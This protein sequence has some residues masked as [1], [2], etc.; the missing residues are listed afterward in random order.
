MPWRL[1]YKDRRTE[2]A[3]ATYTFGFGVV[4][5]G[6]SASMTSPSWATLLRFMSEGNWGVLFILVG[7]IHMLA[8]GI[9]GA[10]WWTPLVRSVTAGINLLAYATIL[11]G[12]F[13]ENSV[14]PGVPT[15][16]LICWLLK[17]I[18][19]RASRDAFV[20]LGARHGT[21]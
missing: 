12:I 18:L 7:G 21:T 2:W 5:S 13:V 16:G 14:S 15:Y 8:L 4:L 1:R 9:N 17:D 3:V 20:V 10:A 11:G 6:P 19:S